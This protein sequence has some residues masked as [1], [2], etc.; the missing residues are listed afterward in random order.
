MSHICHHSCYFV[1][2]FE[3]TIAIKLSS[4]ILKMIYRP[5]LDI[6]CNTKNP[7]LS[8]K[9]YGLYQL[10]I[11]GLVRGLWFTLKCRTA[12]LVV[13]FIIKISIKSFYKYLNCFCLLRKFEN[14]RHQRKI[15]LRRWKVGELQMP[16]LLLWSI[17]EA[18]SSFIASVKQLVKVEWEQINPNWHSWCN[19]SI[20][21]WWWWWSD[22]PRAFLT[23]TM[24]IAIWHLNLLNSDT[25][26]FDRIESAWMLPGLS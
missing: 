17:F 19:Q 6:Q 16:R 5:W 20:Y 22:V 9:F 3:I 4:S 18:N 13:I 12:L 25:W 15:F 7:L 26:V 2:L 23:Y 21:L 10:L 24:I 14:E 1:K 11:L 8:L